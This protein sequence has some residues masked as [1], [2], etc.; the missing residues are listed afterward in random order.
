M[1]ENTT[2]TMEKGELEEILKQSIK[3]AHLVGMQSGKKE[4]SNLIAEMKDTHQGI[5]RGIDGVN[6]RLDVLNGS[7]AKQQDKLAQHDIINAQTT[8]SQQSILQT[9]SEIR[10]KD[11]AS[12]KKSDGDNSKYI[13]ETK[14]VIG[15]FKWL[16]GLIGL[17]NIA[18]LIKLFL[19]E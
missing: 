15:T 11:L 4:S 6:K 18:M 9:I 1:T 16:V 17:G 10:D 7:V 12:L 3:E 14:A 13:T 8:L 2:I 5:I 19:L